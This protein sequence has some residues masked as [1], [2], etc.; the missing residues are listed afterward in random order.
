[1][2]LFKK[3]LE[4]SVKEKQKAS[5]FDVSGEKD[6]FLK[7]GPDSTCMGFAVFLKEEHLGFT[8]PNALRANIYMNSLIVHL[9]QL[10]MIVAVWR[11]ARV[12]DTFAL[13]P[14]DSLDLAL[15]RFVAAMFMHINVEKDIKNGINLMKYVVNHSENFTN[16]YA[17]FM[18]GLLNAIICI[19]VELNVMLILTSMSDVVGVIMKYVSLA[20]IA[21]IPRFYFGSLTAE[22]K[23]T[24]CKDMKLEITK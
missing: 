12:N 9:V 21:N 14:P 19:I 23:L 22:H 1:M 6:K 7:L 20:A 5:I 2:N 11:Y 18:F 10:F 13:I 17:P 3:N 16:Y 8:L 15:A 4:N 24:A